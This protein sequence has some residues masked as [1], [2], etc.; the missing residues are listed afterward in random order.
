ML[1]FL[2]LIWLRNHRALAQIAMS[3]SA[4]LRKNGYSRSNSYTKAG[5]A[6]KPVDDDEELEYS[7]PEEYFSS[8]EDEEEEDYGTT[9]SSSSSSSSSSAA[10]KDHPVAVLRK[11]PIVTSPCKLDRQAGSGKDDNR[12]KTGVHVS[13]FDLFKGFLP[14]S[15]LTKFQLPPQFN[16]PK[17]QLQAY[18]ESVY[19]CDQDLL[20]MCAAAASPLDRFLAVIRWH[21]STT[22]PAPFGRAPYNPILGET[23]HVSAGDLN[24]LCE[25]VSHHPPVSAL[26]ATS[27][28]KKLQLLWWH[29]A[30]P[31]FCGNGVE[32]TILGQRHLNLLEHE[33]IYETSSPKLHICFFPIAGNEWVGNTT[34]RCIKSG[35]EASVSFKGKGF[36]ALH[37]SS[38]KVSGKIWDISTKRI[39]YELNGSWDQVVTLKNKASGEISTLYD[40]QATIVDIHSPIIENLEVCS[41]LLA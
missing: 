35:L 29:Q 13:L 10:K 19:C 37:G 3:P 16:L 1:W 4:S 22:R 18:G 2:S 14:G 30:V 11:V 32:A 15:D 5:A 39:L 6:I 26:Y 41:N 23:H 25:Q 21:I 9:P 17:S 12:S 33:E 7:T 38:N 40:A 27:E 36:F 20:G 8:E 28:S 31:R 34:V 24:V